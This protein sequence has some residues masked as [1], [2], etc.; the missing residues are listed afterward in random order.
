MKRT[1]HNLEVDVCIIYIWIIRMSAKMLPLRG[2]TFAIPLSLS[3]YIYIYIY[4]TLRNILVHC[5]ISYD[6]KRDKAC[7]SRC[8]REWNVIYNLQIWLMNPILAD[9]I[10]RVTSAWRSYHHVSLLIWITWQLKFISNDNVLSLMYASD[11]KHHTLRSILSL[12]LISLSK[13]ER[14]YYS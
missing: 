5:V 11:N 2:D 8:N 6:S 13:F 3:I 1:K 12:S 7:H 9:Q 10:F 4:W 14:Y